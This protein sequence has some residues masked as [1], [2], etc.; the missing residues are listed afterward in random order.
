MNYCHKPLGEYFKPT[1]ID[2]E[3]WAAYWYQID[4]IVNSGLEIKNCLEVGC[5]NKI[6]ASTLKNFDIEVKTLDIEPSIK[7]DYLGSITQAPI[8]DNSF[9]AVLCAEVLEHLPFENFDRALGEL[10][11][12]SRKLVVVSLPHWGRHFSLT[13][14]LPYLHKIDWQKKFNPFPPQH[15]FDGVHYWEIGKE[16]FPLKLIKQKMQA[17]GFKIEKDFICFDSPYHHFFILKKS[18]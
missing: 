12:I 6:V 9:D 17:A 18:A 8:A 1:Y 11:R 5:G 2:K 13:I 15:Q 4:A 14:R 3:R 7:A 16:D 10:R